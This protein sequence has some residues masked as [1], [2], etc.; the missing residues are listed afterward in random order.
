MS[1]WDRIQ[2]LESD[3]AQLHARILRMDNL[4]LVLL[5]ENR[6]LE[7]SRDLARRVAMRLEQENA[8]L[9]G[10]VC[11]VCAGVIVPVPVW[12]DAT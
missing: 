5:D 6:A 1:G 7:Q 11:A 3:L 8:A 10:S 9:G 12:G 2:R 4:N